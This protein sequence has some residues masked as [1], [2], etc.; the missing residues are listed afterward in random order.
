MAEAV[1]C[2]R[3]TAERMR[4]AVEAAFAPLDVNDDGR[5]RRFRLVL[6]GFREFAAAPSAEEL[7]ELENAARALELREPGRA[8]LLRCSAP[9]SA[10][11]SARPT[12][13]VLPSMSRRNLRRR[14]SP[15]GSAR[16]G[17]PTP[18]RSERDRP[19]AD[20][21]ARPDARAG[22]GAGTRIIASRD[23]KPFHSQISN[24][25]RTLP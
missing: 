22:R 19:R 15:A 25:G 5:K 3:R 18:K 11:A 21:A 1:G 24:A 6:R 16:A 17:S 10:R 8:A 12:G 7:A 2:S 4:D 14:P 20:S 23:L 13:G 9:R